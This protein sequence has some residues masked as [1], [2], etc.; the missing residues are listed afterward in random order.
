MMYELAVVVDPKEDEK[1]TQERLT[2]LLT[3]EGFAVSGVTSL[4]K[5]ILAYPLKKRSEGLYLIFS[6]TGSKNPTDQEIRFKLDDTILRTL[7]LKQ[8]AKNNPIIK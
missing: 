6:I 3:K 7:A 1:Q 5:R 8:E 2:T 4:G